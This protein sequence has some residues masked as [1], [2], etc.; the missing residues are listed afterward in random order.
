MLHVFFHPHLQALRLVVVL[1]K[2]R[3]RRGVNAA[4]GLLVLLWTE[5][6]AS[7]HHVNCAVA[8]AGPWFA[9]IKK[10]EVSLDLKGS[11]FPSHKPC[12]EP[13]PEEL[14]AF[15]ELHGPLK[16]LL[17]FQMK[18]VRS[19]SPEWQTHLDAFL[20]T[21]SLANAEIELYLKLKCNQKTLQRV[22]RVEIKYKVAPSVILDVTCKTQPPE[23]VRKG[24]WC[25]GGHPVLGSRLP[26]IIPLHVMDQGLYGE[27]SIQLVTL[28]SPCILQYPNLETKLTELQV[29]VYSPSNLPV[30][31][32]STFF[33]ML[34]AHLD[35]HELGVRG[36]HCFSL[37]DFLYSCIYKIHYENWE[38]AERESSSVQQSLLLFFFLQ[39]RDPFISQLS[40]LMAAERLIE[41]HLEDILSNN[42]QALTAAVQSELKNTLKAQNHR[43]QE[44]EK[45][46]SAVK[47]IL[48][49]SISIV[50]SSSNMEFRNA[51]LNSMKVRDTHELSVSL[52]ESLRR[53]TSWK[54]KSNDSCFSAQT[55]QRPESDVRTRTEI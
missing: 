36:I 2:Q 47:V 23:C 43:T 9:G 1:G 55:E 26:L 50:S 37:K 52:F 40:D 27:L 5:T 15:T 39:H 4:G 17:S 20:H 31:G 38:H 34:P 53:V 30:R 3:K 7:S 21:F 51:C 46:N 54:F 10:N 12:P 19:F 11:L 28:L 18:D 29:F 16:L 6:A 48:N 32:L 49:S 22:F 25:H 14:C 35:T 45:L 8:A 13:E 33:Q 24:C 41:H 44:Q 42:K